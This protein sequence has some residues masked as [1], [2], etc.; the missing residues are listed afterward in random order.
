MYS[1]K[2]KIYQ[3]IPNS[4]SIKSPPQVLSIKTPTRKLALINQIPLYRQSPKQVTPV[5]NKSKV[6]MTFRQKFWSIRPVLHSRSRSTPGNNKIVVM[7]PGPWESFNLFSG[8]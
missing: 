4:K 1:K 2:Q 7:N 3:I 6:F 8:F 5:A